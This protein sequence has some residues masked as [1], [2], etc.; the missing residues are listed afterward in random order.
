MIWCH[1]REPKSS[2]EGALHRA[3]RKVSVVGLLTLA[4]CSTGGSDENSGDRGN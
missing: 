1:D 2:I 4:A 3:V